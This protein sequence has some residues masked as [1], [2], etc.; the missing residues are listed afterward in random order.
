MAGST[1]LRELTA[2]DAELLYRIY[3]STREE[4]LAVTG[5]SAEETDAFLRMQ[6]DAQDRY[7]HAQYPGA[8]F[9]II[10][11]DGQPAGRLYVAQDS[12][13]LNIV[14]IALLPEF[15]GRAIGST[16]IKELQAQAAADGRT[17]T[18]YVEKFNRWQR[19]WRIDPLWPVW[20]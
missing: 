20:N 6:F 14:D 11:C 16:L 18:I 8:S 12:T 1:E 10:L 13:D 15:R 9:Q 17:V 4:E 19:R 5:W 3:S 2:N 7:Y